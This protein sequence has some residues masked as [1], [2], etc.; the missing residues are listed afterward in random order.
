MPRYYAMFIQGSVPADLDRLNAH[1][2][3]YKDWFRFTTGAWLVWTNDDAEAVCKH[4]RALDSGFTVMV[5]KASLDE[6]YVVGSQTAI[7]W[8][9][10]TR[11]D[12]GV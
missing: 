5:T 12:D 3:R 1:M 6:W 4:V 11:F 7:E 8:M 10:R 2:D 9:E